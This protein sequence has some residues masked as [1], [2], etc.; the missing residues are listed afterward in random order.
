MDLNPYWNQKHVRVR[1]KAGLSG[2]FLGR[3]GLALSICDEFV[4]VQFDFV[5]YSPWRWVEHWNL[6]RVD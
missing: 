1:V 4:Q 2:E 6:E 3:I 5:D